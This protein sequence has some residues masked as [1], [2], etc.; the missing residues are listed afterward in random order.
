[1]NGRYRILTQHPD[2]ARSNEY[3]RILNPASFLPLIGHDR[4][5]H[6]WTRVGHARDLKPQEFRQLTKNE[7]Y[8]EGISHRDFYKA[9]NRF[10][11]RANGKYLGSRSTDERLDRV[12][13]HPLVRKFQDFH[14]NTGRPTYDYQPI[15]NF[16]VFEHPDGS[17]FIVARDHG[18]DSQVQRAYMSAV[19]ARGER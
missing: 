17:S 1:M 14:R 15:Q 2:P 18:C 6:Q 16:G 13:G 7:A 9:L 12:K 19:K 4:E 5:H 11:E 10:H 3:V 8:P